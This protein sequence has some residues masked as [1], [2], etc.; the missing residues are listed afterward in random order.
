MI[1]VRQYAFVNMHKCPPKNYA[2]L[3]FWERSGQTNKQNKRSAWAGLGVH[4]RTS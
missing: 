4:Y 1:G 3:F 2:Q